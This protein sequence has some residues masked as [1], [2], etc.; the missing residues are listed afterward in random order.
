MTDYCI[1]KQVVVKKLKCKYKDE[2]EFRHMPFCAL[3]KKFKKENE[4][5]R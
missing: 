5:L 4:K 2:C 3:K 1:K